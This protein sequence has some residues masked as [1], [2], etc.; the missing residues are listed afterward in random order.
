[1]NRIIALTLGILL[2]A[3][4]PGR[5]QESVPSA[6]AG[7]SPVIVKQLRFTGQTQAI[8]QTTVYT[9]PSDG[10]F[11]VTVYQETVVTNPANNSPIGSFCPDLVITNDSGASQ[12]QAGAG[13]LA[14]LPV[15]GSLTNS[16]S[17][18]VQYFFRA[19]ANTPILF[20]D[21]LSGACPGCP[22]GPI[23]PPY[24]FSVYLVV[25]QL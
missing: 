3:A 17:G 25:E 11:R 7:N 16:S 2:F 10:L 21:P 4:L 14:C 23:A 19:K 12:D 6:S 18:P 9:P 20:S 5:T 13:F 24:S 8:P 22:P 15:T 1:M